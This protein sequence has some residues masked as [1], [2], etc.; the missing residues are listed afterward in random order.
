MGDLLP[1][2]HCGEG[3]VSESRILRCGLRSGAGLSG[4]PLVE[5][6][7]HLA[8]QMIHLSLFA[9]ANARNL[10]GALRDHVP[11]PG[12]DS[13]LGRRR[14]HNGFNPER[15][16]VV[17]LGG[18]YGWSGHASTIRHGA[19]FYTVKDQLPAQSDAD[20]AQIAALTRR[21]TCIFAAGS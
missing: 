18:G 21:K 11:E 9:G 20:Q 14:F 15:R 16:L 10:V 4:A 5:A 3:R 2:P 13:P 6:L 1:L 17:R 19:L 8:D 12:A 7:H